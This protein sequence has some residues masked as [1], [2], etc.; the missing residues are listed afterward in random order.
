MRPKRMYLS[1]VMLLGVALMGSG[2]VALAQGDVGAE[3]PT[4]VTRTVA[5]DVGMPE[6]YACMYG[7]WNCPVYA[8][9]SS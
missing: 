2:A 7:N 1:V 6:F 4:G 9:V 8:I 3:A 5:L